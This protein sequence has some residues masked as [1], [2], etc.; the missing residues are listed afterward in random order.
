M[1]DIPAGACMVKPLSSMFCEPVIVRIAERPLLV[2]MLFAGLFA[3]LSSYVPVVGASLYEFH[4]V[5][6]PE[7]RSV[8]CVNPWISTFS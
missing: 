6:T 5:C 3:P 4:T 8:T 2:V 7:P 1:H